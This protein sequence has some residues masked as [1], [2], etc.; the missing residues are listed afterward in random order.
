MNYLFSEVIE[1]WQQNIWKQT[2]CKGPSS[3][4]QMNRAQNIRIVTCKW[5]YNQVRFVFAVFAST[6]LTLNC[7]TQ[8]R[9]N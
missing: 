7:I 6:K 9:C 2:D 8:A 3:T 1:Y 5:K 4:K